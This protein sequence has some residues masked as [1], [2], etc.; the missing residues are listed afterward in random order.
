MPAEA[1]ADED[2]LPAELT[3][4]ES[5]LFA[6]FN[7]FINIDDALFY[8]QQRFD[9]F[10]FYQNPLLSFESVFLIKYFN[11]QS[12][13]KSYM[14][15]KTRVPD[16]IFFTFGVAEMDPETIT[17]HLKFAQIL[18]EE[19]VLLAQQQLTNVKTAN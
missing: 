8:L 13:P 17:N 10:K 7:V 6:E 1:N 18:E 12:W 3:I 14:M 15:L 5:V 11:S 9:A 2:T 16:D 4:V 19:N